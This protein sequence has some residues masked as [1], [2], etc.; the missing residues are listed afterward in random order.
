MGVFLGELLNDIA[1]GRVPTGLLGKQLLLATPEVLGKLLPLAG[2]VA[3]MWGLG[4]FYR[5]HEMVVMR[6]SGFNWRYLLKPLFALVLPI[7]GLLLVLTLW[8]APRATLLSQ[9]ILEDAFR[10]ASLWGLQSG[11][12]HIMQSGKLVIYVE[13]LDK[14]GRSMSN[15]FV[16]QT[17]DERS[18]VWTA[19]E[20]EYWLDQETGKRYLTLSDGQVTESAPN[21][22][23]VRVLQFERNDLQ[24][25][26]PPRRARSDGLETRSPAELLRADDAAAKAEFQWRVSPALAVVILGLLAI[27]LSHS[28]PRE[29]RGARAALG[30]FVYAIYANTLNLSRSWVSTETLPPAIGMWWVHGLVLLL[31]LFWLQ[32]Q[33][34]M[35]GS[36]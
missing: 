3:V 2:F 28:S 19:R 6:S 5:D 27:P 32:R 15:V 17:D 31:A 34:R 23:N 12:F 25:P 8:M 29:G 13:S 21:E 10:S 20:G 7:A 1:D 35:V 36:S 18:Q 14:D 26:E 11:R 30:I 16:R 9:S 33:G 24:L 22:R 4:R